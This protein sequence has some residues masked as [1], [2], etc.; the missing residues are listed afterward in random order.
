MKK[1]R[2]ESGGKLLGVLLALAM[3]VGLFPGMSLTAY[4]ADDPYASEQ[5]IMAY[6]EVEYNRTKDIVNFTKISAIPM[7]V[8]K[9][10]GDN[11]EYRIYPLVGDYTSGTEL[12]ISGNAWRADQA[13]STLTG[14]LGEQYIYR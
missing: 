12:G 7:Y 6:L 4:A 11:L 1:N 14:I 8:D 9:F 5:E 10:W 2:K 3:I 13:L